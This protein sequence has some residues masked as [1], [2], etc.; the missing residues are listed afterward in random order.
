LL[1]FR[2][3]CL[4]NKMRMIRANISYKKMI[5]SGVKINA[6]VLCDSIPRENKK[7]LTGKQEMDE[8][9]MYKEKN[10]KFLVK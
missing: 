8:T 7:I 4:L 3:W 6:R 10:E 2:L 9:S 5:E 1:R